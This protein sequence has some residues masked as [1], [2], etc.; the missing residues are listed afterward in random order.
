MCTV[1]MI[2][3]HYH[4]KW[5]HRYPYDGVPAPMITYP[6]MPTPEEIQEFR[7]LL[8]RAREYDRL[9]NEPDCENAGKRQRLLDLAEELGVEIDFV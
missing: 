1:S 8:D 9:H 4:D 2:M 5:R 7:E 6:P 3:D